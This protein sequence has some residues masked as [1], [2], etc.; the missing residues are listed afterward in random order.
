MAESIRVSDVIPAPPETVFV[1]WLDSEQHSAFTGG[2]ATF[3]GV[4]G[5]FTAWDGYIQGTTF[6]AY[7][8]QRIVQSW[9]TTEFPADAPP[10]RLEV[11]LE[12]D[13]GGT[14][15]T[16]IHSDIPEGQA[17]SY[18]QGW[19]DHYFT[20]MKQYFGSGAVPHADSPVAKPMPA[21]RKAAAKKPAKKAAAR[22]APQRKAAAKKKAAQRKPAKKKAARRGKKKAARR[23]RR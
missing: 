16:L 10:S 13:E 22:K 4:G 8:H 3:S 21:A 2:K 18:E 11:L 15:I 7:P 20:P 6:E 9:R 17:A 23:G 12:A 1:A 5:P 14:R 19:R